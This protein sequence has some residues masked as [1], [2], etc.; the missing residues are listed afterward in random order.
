MERNMLIL[1]TGNRLMGDDSIGPNIVKA[2]ENYP[3]P[4]CIKTSIIETDCWSL[5]TLEDNYQAII[6]IDGLDIK[7]EVGN[8]YLIPGTTLGSGSRPFSLHDI[9]WQDVLML[10][11]YLEKTTLFGIQID[12]LE[13]GSGLS[14]I[15]KGRIDFYAAELYNF[16]V[17]I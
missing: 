8:I 7:G 17:N 1:G 5:L 3:L 11:N 14:P 9:T 13:M 6:V 15:L 12:T 4:R 16:I 10:K 2:L